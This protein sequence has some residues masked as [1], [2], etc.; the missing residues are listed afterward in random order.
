M[1]NTPANAIPPGPLW[2]NRDYVLLWSG[3]AVSVVGSNISLIA[4][5]LLV[6]AITNSPAVA[7]LVAAARSLP[8]LFLT[9]LAGALVDRWNRK[10]TMFACS[11]IS[12]VAMSSIVVAA[13]FDCLTVSHI[14]LVS[15]IEGSCAVF[16][17][18]AET[19]A[20]VQVVHQRQLPQAIAQQQLQYSVGAILGP[21]LGGALFSV[22]HLLP[23]IADA[24]SYG[25]SCLSLRAL[26]AR[27][28][29]GGAAT[30]RQSLKAEIGEGIIWLWRHSLI[31]YMAGLTGGINLVTSGGVLILI[32]LANQQGAAPATTGM[33]LAASGAGGVLGALLAP[34]IQRRLSF[35]QAIIGVCWAYFFV[36]ALLPLAVTPL[37]LMLVAAIATM[38]SP[39]YDAVQMSYRLAL[40]PN[41]LQGRVN[42]AFRLAADGAKAIGTAATG[43]ML[44]LVGANATLLLAAGLFAILATLTTL[45][46]RVR[47][48]PRLDSL[49]RV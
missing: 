32:V 23:F 21:P 16:F 36:W 10:A 14:A 5:P 25:A 41:E 24:C 1:T 27:L 6:L 28:A 2:R 12:A 42:S 18:L 47:Q 46:R 33:V 29:A 8:Y 11:A 22:S 20:L 49:T 39:A 9:L 4:F 17:R 7:G 43:L 45:N 37:L 13:T 44:E 19:S 40:I 3:Q 31:R 38:I 48:A 15:L 30:T 34:T 35:G 26:R